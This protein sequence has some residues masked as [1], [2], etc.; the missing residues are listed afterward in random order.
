MVGRM[1]SGLA[2][3]VMSI[4][5]LLVS[6]VSARAAI[7]SEWTFENN[8]TPPAS[9]TTSAGPFFAEQGTFTATAAASSVHAVAAT[10]SA[11]VGNGSSKSFSA[12]TYS[13]GDYFQFVSPTTGFSGIQLLVDQAASSTGPTTWKVAYSTDGTN[14][15]DLPGGAYTLNTSVSFSSASEKTTN[16]PRYLFDLSSISALDNQPSVTIRL[17]DTF[18]TGAPTGTS[19]VDNVTFGTNLPVPPPLPEP[20]GVM[21]LGLAA[22]GAMRRRR[23]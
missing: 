15:T 5:L 7:I 20:S 9:A 16:P 13:L 6:G 23:R 18:A 21:I 10:F 2:L 12:N 22:A 19:R 3:R 4:A 11:P 14:F 1:G 17:I 8:Y